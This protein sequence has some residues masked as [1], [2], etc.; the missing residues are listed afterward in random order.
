MDQPGTYFA[1]YLGG[2]TCEASTGTPQLAL[3]FD[4]THV[5]EDDQ[6][7]ELAEV[8][9]RTVYLSLTDSAW[10]YAKKKLVRLNFNGDWDDP[11]L[12]P[13]DDGCEL[14]CAED[15]YK[16]VSRMKWDIPLGDM[17]NKPAGQDVKRR[18]AALWKSETAPKARPKP[19]PKAAAKPGP[20]KGPTAPSAPASEAT[21]VHA[22]LTRLDEVSLL[23]VS[24]R[25]AEMEAIAQDFEAKKADFTGAEASL[26]EQRLAQ[27]A[28]TLDIPF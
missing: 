3:R 7:T 9:V 11:Q 26:V 22:L 18:L 17:E 28:D 19:A 6:W 25:P 10:P 8:L 13:G 5:A 23:D 14:V 16:G 24:L 27:V 20:A 1:A 21:E 15:I 4:V 2:E 12:A